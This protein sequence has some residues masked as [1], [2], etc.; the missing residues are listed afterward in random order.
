M[1]LWL[2]AYLVGGDKRSECIKNILITM[3]ATVVCYRVD[4]TSVSKV[5]RICC[6]F[7]EQRF[8]WDGPLYPC[9][10]YANKLYCV[11]E[12]GTKVS[13]PSELVKLGLHHIS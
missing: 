2:A 6:G 1:Y 5:I 9:P 8:V 3:M 7:P 12:E 10:S 11:V 13:N 4:F